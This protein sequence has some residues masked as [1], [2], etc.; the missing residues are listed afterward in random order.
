VKSSN[1]FRAD[2]TPIASHVLICKSGAPM[3]ADPA[4][5]AWRH[6]SPLTRTRP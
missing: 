2:F 5:L 4:D 6:L 1:H 3:A